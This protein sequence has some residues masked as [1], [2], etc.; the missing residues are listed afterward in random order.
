MMMNIVK[1]YEELRITLLLLE[2]CMNKS[3]CF[4]A[5]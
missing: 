5:T 3:G 1:G 4:C 2:I